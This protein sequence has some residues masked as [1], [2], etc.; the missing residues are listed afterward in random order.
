MAMAYEQD[1]RPMAPHWTELFSS[2][3]RLPEKVCVVAPGP[4]GEGHYREIPKDHF[5]I[6]VSKAVLIEELQPAM[7][8]MT[9]A[10]QDWF[11]AADERCACC[12]VFGA[13]ALRDRPDLRAGG[14][15]FYFQCEEEELVVNGAIQ[16]VEGRVRR[17]ASISSCAVQIAY[18][19]GA[20]QILLCGVDMSGDAYWDG[21]MNPDQNH[22]ETWPAVNG[23]HALIHYLTG[24]RG[25]RISS[26]SPTKLKIPSY[27][28]TGKS[29]DHDERPIAS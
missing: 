27:V 1:D 13:G 29:A 10:S 3:L 2:R 24:Q 17:G 9:H 22:G 25:I 15:R 12:R 8:I 28:E 14:D 5:L 18:N 11:S 20:K 6:A 21:S 7:W 26:L 4:N 23:F 19:L 16:P